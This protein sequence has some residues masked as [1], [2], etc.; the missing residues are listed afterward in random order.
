MELKRTSTSTRRGNALRVLRQI[1]GWLGL[2][3]AVLGLLFGLS[4]FILNHRNVMK[5]P[6]VK[7]EE[8]LIQL[9][10]SQPHPSDLAEFTKFIQ[11][12]LKINHDPFKP[13]PKKASDT[14]NLMATDKAKE[15]RFLG[16]D[17]QQ[18]QQLELTFQLPNAAI[19]AEYVV[20]NR[21]ATVK[22]EDANAWGFIT[23][24][25]KGVGANVGW[26]L[27]VD[28]LAGALIVLSITGVLIWTKM[29]GSRIVM[30]GLIGTSIILSFWF[31]L[32]ML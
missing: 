2:W 14:K 16:Q 13:K 15:A 8:S 28:S 18:P 27:L 6:A 31:T 10:V 1:H 25:H 9:E 12:T 32:S 19:H 7:M 21:F 24:M 3:G 11:K 4:G 20:G 29:R 5:I 30:S 17:I 22:R 26:I 23:R